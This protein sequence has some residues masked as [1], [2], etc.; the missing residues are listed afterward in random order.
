MGQGC[1]TEIQRPPVARIP[2]PQ[3]SVSHNINQIKSTLQVKENRPKF[4]SKVCLSVYLSILSFTVTGT[5]FANK[6]EQLSSL[7]FSVIICITTPVNIASVYRIR[8]AGQIDYWRLLHRS[9]EDKCGKRENMTCCKVRKVDRENYS[10][11]LRQDCK[12]RYNDWG[13]GV[14]QHSDIVSNLQFAQKRMSQWVFII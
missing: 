12:D 6:N 7:F 1:S 14:M 2:S 5:R 3:R 10:D 13:S 11:Q 8:R 4:F 9:A